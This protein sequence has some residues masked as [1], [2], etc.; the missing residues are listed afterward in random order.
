[1]KKEHWNN[2]KYLTIKCF[3]N[4]QGSPVPKGESFQYPA[5]DA[6]RGSSWEAK[7]ATLV[8]SLDSFEFRGGTAVGKLSPIPGFTYVSPEELGLR[9]VT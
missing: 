4:L 9:Q 3:S 7:A 8:N 6:S 1:M 5:W 2:W